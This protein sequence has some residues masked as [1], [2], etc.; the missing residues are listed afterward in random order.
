[1]ERY[2]DKYKNTHVQIKQACE[3]IDSN[4]CSKLESEV[5]LL[6][7]Q[8]LSIDSSEWQ[9]SAGNS[10]RDTIKKCS[11]KLELVANNINIVFSKSEVAYKNTDLQLEQLKKMNEYL[12]NLEK[13]KPIKNNFLVVETDSKGNSVDTYP[14]YDNKLQEWQNLI[15]DTTNNCVAISSCV[16]KYLEILEEI[17]SSSI[18]EEANQYFKNLNIPD[19]VTY[20]SFLSKVYDNTVVLPEESVGEEP[21]VQTVVLT[22][23]ALTTFMK[24]NNIPQEDYIKIEKTTVSVNGVDFDVY[25]VYDTSC[26]PEETEDFKAYADGCLGN[27]GLIDTAVL[28]RI[29]NGGTSIVFE[30]TYRCDGGSYYSGK[31]EFNAAAYCNSVNRNVVQFYHPD[32]YARDYYEESIVHELGHAYDFTLRHD[33][34]GDIQAGISAWND[35]DINGGSQEMFITD[36]SGTPYTW[37]E[38]IEKEARDALNGIPNFSL[39]NYENF[40]GS[41]TEYFAEAFKEYYMSSEGR[42]RFAFVAPKTYEAME[43]LVSSESK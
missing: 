5:S 32:D 39:Y 28:E 15:N 3:C 41:H 10:F 31:E 4:P 2:Y 23:D 12:V 35:S 38:L 26:S 30:Q 16:D 42:E 36:S 24:D 37:G 40:Q 8:V 14:G 1:M 33:A 27:A 13:L 18:N 11:D 7:E 20:D 34:S 43:L 29:R 21:V 6:S 17:N 25:Y 19:V 22:G 9:D